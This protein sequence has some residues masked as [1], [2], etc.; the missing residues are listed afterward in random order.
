MVDQTC[1]PIMKKALPTNGPTDGQTDGRT[2]GQTDGRTN[3]PTNGRKD[4]LM[5]RVALLQLKSWYPPSRK[6]PFD[7]KTLWTKKSSITRLWGQ[8]PIFSPKMSTYFSRGYGNSIK[9]SFSEKKSGFHPSNNGDLTPKS[10][11]RH[12]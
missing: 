7:P 11:P 5:V 9:E 12:K 1:S 2:D 6:W 8:I 3:G 10:P 4:K